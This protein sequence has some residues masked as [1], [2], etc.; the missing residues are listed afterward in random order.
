MPEKDRQ[1][2]QSILTNETRP[3]SLAWV[4]TMYESMGYPFTAAALRARI[5]ALTVPLDANMPEQTRQIVRSI[6]QNE[7]HPESLEMAAGMYEAMGY[8]YAGYALRQRGSYLRTGQTHSTPTPSP[9]DTP[10]VPE[11]TFSEHTPQTAAPEHS[12]HSFLPALALIGSCLA[13]T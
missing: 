6:L 11:V 4:A 13:F 1:I 7:T 2:V 5:N 12:N 3:E 9:D 8:P 10:G